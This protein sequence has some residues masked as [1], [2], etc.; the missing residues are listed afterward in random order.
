MKIRLILS[1]VFS[2]KTVFLRTKAPEKHYEFP[3]TR[4]LPTA[5]RFHILLFCLSCA[6]SFGS[7]GISNQQDISSQPTR[8][9]SS[10][11]PIA[12]IG[13]VAGVVVATGAG[14]A[15]VSEF[16]RGEVVS[17]VLLSG[18][19]AITAPYFGTAGALLA[20]KLAKCKKTFL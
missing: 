18:A 15:V 14:V 11:K 6:F 2:L 7:Y 9:H 10:R 17:A 8:P 12:E 3:Q 5:R 19:V 4:F 13:Y 1:A 16:A 20:N